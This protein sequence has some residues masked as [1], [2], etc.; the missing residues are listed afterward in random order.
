MHEAN[1]TNCIIDGSLST[2]VSFQ[3]NEYKEFNYS[4]N[5]CLIKLDPIINTNNNTHYENTIINQLP[6]FT[7]KT[8]NDFHLTEES[9]AINAGNNST[10]GTIDIEGN[11]INVNSWFECANYVNGGWTLNYSNFSGDVFFFGVT[12]GLLLLYFSLKILVSK[13][14]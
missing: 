14:T 12:S 5:N 9:P 6:K 1:F 2:E 4:F 10:L 11:I 13:K 3:Q 7:N 8:E